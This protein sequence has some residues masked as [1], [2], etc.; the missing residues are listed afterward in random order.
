MEVGRFGYFKDKLSDPAPEAN[1]QL[2]N[3]SHVHIATYKLIRLTD[4]G[5]GLW[6]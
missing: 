1:S 3:G 5:S 6:V 2:H 4:Q